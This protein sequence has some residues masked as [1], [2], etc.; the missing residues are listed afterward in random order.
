MN[1]FGSFLIAAALVITSLMF[2]AT[3]LVAGA[4]AL[5]ALGVVIT[6]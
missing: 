1:D 6:G 3:L 4:W 5:S 2:A